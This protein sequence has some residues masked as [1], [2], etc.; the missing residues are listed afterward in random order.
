MSRS[1]ERAA[2]WGMLSVLCW[3]AM[4]AHSGG[5]NPNTQRKTTKVMGLSKTNGNIASSVKSLKLR[6][7]DFSASY[8]ASNTA[9]SMNPSPLGMTRNS[10]SKHSKILST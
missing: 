7:A 2:P 4:L 10:V 1:R 5:V 9:Y 3:L 6:V 8:P